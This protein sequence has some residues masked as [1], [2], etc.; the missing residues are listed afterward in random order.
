MGSSTR[1]FC[2]LEAGL[3]YVRT[4]L[5][6]TALL[7]PA[8]SHFN[9]AHFI[10]RVFRDDDRST[11]QYCTLIAMSTVEP[12]CFNALPTANVDN[13]EENNLHVPK[14]HYFIHLRKDKVKII[15]T[16]FAKTLISF[17]LLCFVGFSAAQQKDIDYDIAVGL[18]GLKE[19]TKD[20]ALLAQLIRDMQVCTTK[21]EIEGSIQFV[22][23]IFSG[24]S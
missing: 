20:P 23:R 10:V 2:V 14:F 11:V 8:W 12:S 4:V 16:M 3:Q 18:Q 24:E 17:L 15:S 21:N 9:F 13:S 6:S 1:L 5:R 7:Q 19:A 22:I